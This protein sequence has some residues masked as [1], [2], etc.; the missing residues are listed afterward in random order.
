MKKTLLIAAM[1]L[2]IITLAQTDNF[3]ITGKISTPSKDSKAYITYKNDGQNIIDSVKL[4]NGNFTFKGQ[5]ATPSPVTL[6]LSH[7]DG[8]MRQS[9]DRFRVYVDKGTTTLTAKD[10]IKYASVQGAKISTEYV[11]YT[12]SFAKQTAAL[13]A[14]DREWATASDAEKNAGTIGE[15]L[16]TL[17]GP[18]NEEKRAIQKNYIAKNP[19]SYFSLLAIQEIA[20]SQMNINEVDPLFKKLSENI[21]TSSEGQLFAKKIEVA[22]RT[23]LGAIAPDFSQADANGKQVKLS[24]FR[25]KY[26]LLDFWASWCLPCRKENPNI[27]AAY[28]K[29]KN[30]NFT[31]VGVA[32]DD[33]S[34]RSNWLKVIEV[35]KLDWTQLS[36]LK[37]WGNEA[38]ILYGVAGIPQNYLIGPDGKILAVNLKGEMLHEKLIELLEK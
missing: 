12:S 3:T 7:E 2:P 1:A 19:N 36:D 20:G 9:K 27:V 18:L 21:R 23:Q 33:P 37:G 10:S 26:V 15:K 5:V 8:G 11:D 35:D 28:H 25:G 17:S 13:N 31:V 34:S 30:K 14:L 6:I 24:D 22:R 32:L 38:S 16:A 29:F 4:Q